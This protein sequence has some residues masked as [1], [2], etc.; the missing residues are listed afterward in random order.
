MT[1]AHRTLPFGTKLKVTNKRNGKS[2]VVRINDRGP[3]IKGPCHRPVQGRC[4]EARL[5]RQGRRQDLHG[6]GLSRAPQR[7]S[8]LAAVAAIA[9]ARSGPNRCGNRRGN[10]SR[11]GRGRPRTRSDGRC[12]PPRPGNPSEKTS[13]RPSAAHHAGAPC[14]GSSRSAP[15]WL[16]GD[17]DQFAVR[18]GARGRWPPRRSRHRAPGCPSM[19]WKSPPESTKKTPSASDPGVGL[20]GQKA[21]PH[22]AARRHR[23]A[24]RR[25]RDR[26]RRRGG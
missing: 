16:V 10:R 18:H 14:R 15:G 17:G 11:A 26:R 22:I 4:Q 6:Q 5:H 7:P 21:R 9:S 13:R 8:R 24:P 3:F 20:D 1:A 19:V 25:R 12:R 2:V 23:A